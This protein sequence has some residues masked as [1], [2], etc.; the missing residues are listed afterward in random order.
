MEAVKTR[1]EEAVDATR[2]A[3]LDSALRLLTERGYAATSLD[4]VTAA[5]RVTKGA[6][7]HHFPGGKR[8]VFQAVFEEVDRRLGEDITAAIEPGAGPWEVVEQGL[9]GYLRGVRDPV[10]RRIMFQDGPVALGHDKYRELDGCASRDLLAA[11]LG[12]LMEAG[13]IKQE[14]LELM[15]RLTFAM[16]GEAGMLVSESDDPDRVCSEVRGL[17]LDMLRGLAR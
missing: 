7:Y 5:A 8:A 14:P 9:D 12:G 3:L 15:S 4:D 13:E 11:V 17:L 16:L 2:A 6:L 10:V 1:R